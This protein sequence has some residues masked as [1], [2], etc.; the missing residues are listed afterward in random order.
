MALWQVIW[1]SL[2]T[3]ICYAEFTHPLWLCPASSLNR[4]SMGS[5]PQTL[6]PWKYQFKKFSLASWPV[7][8]HLSY[9]YNKKNCADVSSL[10]YLSWCPYIHFMQAYNTVRKYGIIFLSTHTYP[11]ELL[12]IYIQGYRKRWTGIETAIT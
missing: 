4:T 12:Y 5:I 10:V 6:I 2:Q 3:N 8:Q 11:T 7:P 1:N 9:L